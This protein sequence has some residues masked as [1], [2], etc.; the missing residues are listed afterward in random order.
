MINSIDKVLKSSTE[1]QY[2]FS[3]LIPTWNNINYLKLCIEGLKK[4][5]TTNLQ[6]IIIINEGED[7]TLKWVMEQEEL[8]YVYSPKNIGICYALNACRSLILSDYVVYMNDDMYPLHNWD[9]KL[10]DE[11]IKYGKKDFMFS[12][13]MIEPFNTGNPCVLVKDY[14][15]DIETFKKEE[16]EK[17][18]STFSRSDWWGSTWPPNVMHIDVWDLAGGMSIEYTP[19]FSSDPDL[20]MKFYQMGVREFKG[21]GNSFVYHFGCKSTGRVKSNKGTDTFLMKWGIS[22]RIFTNEVIKRG[23]EYQEDLP[24]K[25]ISLS[26][27]IRNKIKKLRVA[28]K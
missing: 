24:S 23:K 26:N 11:I 8:N 6:L 17:D 13:T 20:S 22:S 9:G 7:G 27:K 25:E 28:L 1:K 21:L 4:N 18:S 14:G 12:S 5:S 19:G 15:R 3:V 16:I 2:N 10:N